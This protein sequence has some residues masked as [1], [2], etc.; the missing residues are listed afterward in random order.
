MK[1][2]FI[3]LALFMLCSCAHRVVFKNVCLFT[4]CDEWAMVD[5]R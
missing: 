3:L 1:P 4:P 5:D 2:L